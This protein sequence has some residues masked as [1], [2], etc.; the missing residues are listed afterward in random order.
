MALNGEKGTRV[1]I[2]SPT[3]GL[4]SV[5]KQ[6]LIVFWQLK[7]RVAS[8]QNSQ[9]TID[10]WEG[11]NGGGGERLPSVASVDPLP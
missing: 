11:N 1:C 3:Q 7:G 2:Y 9:N 10:F 5:H 6:S 8:Q 4:H